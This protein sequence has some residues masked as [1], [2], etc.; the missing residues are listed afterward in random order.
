MPFSFSHNGATARPTAIRVRVT[1]TPTLF[2]SV[3][4]DPAGGNNFQSYISA[5]PIG[6]V[7]QQRATFPP[8]FRFG[9]AAS[10]GA[11][12]NYHE[13]R[14]VVVDDGAAASRAHENAIAATS[15][16]A[17][18]ARTRS[19]SV[20]SDRSAR[21]ARRRSS[22]RCRP[23]LHIRVR[24]ASD[25]R[26]PPAGKR[27]R[28][29]RSRRFRA[30]RTP[31]GESVQSAHAQHQYRSG[32]VGNRDEHCDRERR[33]CGERADRE[34]SDDHHHPTLTLTK[35]SVGNFVVGK[36]GT[37]TLS[38]GN[39]GGL[40][41]SGPITV[42]DTLPTGLT[43]VSASGSGWTCSDSG[44]KRLRARRR[45]RSP[46]AVTAR[47]LPS[48]T[49]ILANALPS[50]TNTATASGGGAPN[51]ANAS[52]TVPV[53][54]FPSLTIQ[55]QHTGDFVVGQQ[56]AFTINVGNDGNVDTSTNITVTDTLPA[57]LTY[58][59][60]TGTGWA[61]SAA[62]Q[63]VTCI[64][65]TVIPVGG[66]SA[67]ITLVTAVGAAAI[68]SATNT[69]TAAGGNAPNTPTATDVVTVTGVPALTLTK[70]HTGNFAVGAQGTFTLL[71]GNNG[72]AATAGLV[73][74]A[75]TLPA[76][77]TF[78]AGTGPNWTCAGAGQTVTCTTPALRSRSV[79]TRV[80]LR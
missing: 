34:R 4:L 21:A 2:V 73:T 9:W 77:L 7:A 31:G 55:K 24:V 17:E 54:G 72:T 75:D 47:R 12:T 58:V 60:A 32:H 74:V 36:T 69:A 3:E 5:F 11:Q 1:L 46:Q 26:A 19:R 18:W 39:S 45:R 37:F 35:A 52:V 70:S 13:I 10:T 67:P 79:E 78:V 15:P 8:Q 61:C 41:T 48:L 33:R 44:G 51:T 56:G 59:S 49:N 28:V 29:R 16:Q 65:P 71:A 20:T 53:T 63:I 23:A 80:R 40:A 57:G 30:A 68:P 38:P 43:F 25:G 62:G 66:T 6:N 27:S 14:N 76:G 22:T 50:V 64:S 42:V